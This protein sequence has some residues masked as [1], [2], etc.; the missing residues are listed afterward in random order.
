MAT[1]QAGRT[2]AQKSAAKL[3]FAIPVG[4]HAQILPPPTL[5]IYDFCDFKLPAPLP[6]LINRQPSDFFSSHSPSPVNAEWQKGH[7]SVCYMHLDDTATTYFP[8][9]V[10][11]FWVEVVAAGKTRKR[12]LGN[13]DWIRKQQGLKKSAKTWEAAA[14]CDMNLKSLPWGLKKE[15]LSDR[16]QID[17]LWRVLG[18][19]WMSGSLLNNAMHLLQSE[20]NLQDFR[21]EGTGFMEGL[22]K[23]FADSDTEYRETTTYQWIVAVGDDLMAGKKTMVSYAHV[24]GN[25][26]VFIAV[27][28]EEE[29]LY[30]GNPF[31][32]EVPQEISDLYWAWCEE[33]APG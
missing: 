1:N 29:V 11:M 6:T 24:D 17:T 10:I 13:Q 26:W 4:S 31:R 5:S 27:D 2:A 28:A 18:P 33:L 14:E 30:L 23:V 9:W 32:G 15:G 16:E 25:H 7:A 22:R 21:L 20:T 8:L 12:W 3:D 19:N